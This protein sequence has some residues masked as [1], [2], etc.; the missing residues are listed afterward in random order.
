MTGRAFAPS[1]M[2]LVA[3]LAA[4]PAVARPKPLGNATAL[5]N[6]LT[7]GAPVRAFSIIRR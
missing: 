7:S 3:A 5:F 4:A 6:A 2:L 1:L